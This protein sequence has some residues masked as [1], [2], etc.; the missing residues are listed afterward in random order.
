[1]QGEVI[2]IV[3]TGFYSLFFIFASIM[4]KISEQMKKQRRVF[5]RQGN[6]QMESEKNTKRI[7]FFLVKFIYYFLR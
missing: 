4:K 2:F 7:L 3:V 1:M 6:S 5:D